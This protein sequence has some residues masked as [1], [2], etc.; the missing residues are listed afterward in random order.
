MN[1]IEQILQAGRRWPDES[2]STPQPEEIEHAAAQLSFSF[3]ESYLAFISL[4]GLSE[5]G[6]KNTVLAPSEIV[7]SSAALPDAEHVPFGDDG[8]GDLFCW[9]KEHSGEPS[10]LLW[11]HET[12]EYSESS[13]SFTAWLRENRM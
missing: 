11:N 13:K 6:F 10:V 9:Q 1:E 3:P 5:R 4:G 8:C 2:H 12:G 7:A